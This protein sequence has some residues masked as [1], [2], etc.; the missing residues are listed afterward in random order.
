M[1][2]IQQ[3]ADTMHV[4]YAT[5]IGRLQDGRASIHL[6]LVLVLVQVLPL[7]FVCCQLPG[8]YSYSYSFFV[9]SL[10]PQA[11]GLLTSCVWFLK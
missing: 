8:I 4:S 11:G 3:A 9:L 6:A 5:W 7:S 2:D 1:E 10:L